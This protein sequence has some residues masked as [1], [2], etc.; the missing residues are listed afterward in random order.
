MSSHHGEGGFSSFVASRGSWVVQVLRAH[1]SMEGRGGW[2]NIK[3]HVNAQWRVKRGGGAIKANIYDPAIDIAK[4]I[5]KAFSVALW[6][7]NLVKS[8]MDAS[9]PVWLYSEFL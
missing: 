5:L 3:C 1:A 6:F 4:E 9:L 2:H 8:L 7:E